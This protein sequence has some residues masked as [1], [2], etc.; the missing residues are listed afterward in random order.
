M[1]AQDNAEERH[2]VND[3]VS[4]LRDMLLD[5]AEVGVCRKVRSRHNKLLAINLPPQDSR[6]RK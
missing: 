1:F 5:D 3:R 4:L 2:V 6:I